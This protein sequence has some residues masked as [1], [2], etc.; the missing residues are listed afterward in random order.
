MT[1]DMQLKDLIIEKAWSD[2]AF[3]EQLITDA[4]TAIQQAF[5]INIPAHIELVAVEET[6]SRF[7]L[8]IPMN[9]AHALKSDDESTVYAQW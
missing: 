6:P 3:K 5:N 4:K 7:Q 8:V 9:P 2:P 1:T